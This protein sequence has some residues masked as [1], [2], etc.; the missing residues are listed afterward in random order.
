MQINSK[1]TWTVKTDIDADFD[2]D[3]FLPEVEDNNNFTTNN[4]DNKIIHETISVENLVSDINVE[5]TQSRLEIKKS[6]DDKCT[7]EI[8]H[9]EKFNY[10]VNSADN[11]LVIKD[12]DT[13]IWYEKWF[14]NF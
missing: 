12:D 5:I 10:S 6:T 7:V 2:D 3:D 4:G 9:V 1:T 8:D 11:K 14:F 13:R